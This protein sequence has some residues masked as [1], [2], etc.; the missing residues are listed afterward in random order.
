MLDGQKVWPFC[1]VKKSMYVSRTLAAGHFC[2]CAVSCDAA[3]VL[4][5]VVVVLLLL[6]LLSLRLKDGDGLAQ[7]KLA[8][9]ASGEE[10]GAVDGW[11]RRESNRRAVV[12][13]R[14]VKSDGRAAGSGQ[15]VPV[16]RQERKQAQLHEFRVDEGLLRLMATLRKMVM[17]QCLLRY[18]GCYGYATGD[19]C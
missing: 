5:V 9:T 11:T 18:T 14:M 15:C 17:A 16:W 10:V 6:L 12:D 1:L 8:T 7:K 2:C 19:A 3:I 4:V 13:P